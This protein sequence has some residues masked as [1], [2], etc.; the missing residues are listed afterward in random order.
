MKTFVLKSA[1]LLAII[2]ALAIALSAVSDIVKDRIQYRNEAI[3]SISQSHAA[4]QM[5][6]GPTLIVPYEEHYVEV[7][8]K[9]ENGKSRVV[10]TKRSKAGKL[11]LLPEKLK[12]DGT[13]EVAPRY[14]GLF[15]VNTYTADLN[16]SG[17][18]LV[19][20]E[21][22]VQGSHADSQILFQSLASA[23]MHIADA[24]GIQFA[25]VTID[26][27]QIEPQPG[28]TLPTYATGLHVQAAAKPLAGRTVAF[29][30]RLKIVGTD[31]I[32]MLPLGRHN[33][34]AL[35]SP[36]PH[37]SFGGGTLPNQR[38]VTPAG[39]SAT[40]EVTSLASQ[41]R[42]VWLDALSGPQK[43]DLATHEGFGVRLID[44]VDVYTLTDRATKYGVLFIVFVLG[45]Y[46]AY[47]LLKRLQL[48]PVQYTLCGLA[49]VV[50]F[51]LLLGLA[52]Q[53]GFAAAYAAASTACVA[54]LGFYG[55]YMFGH[56]KRSIP[57]TGGLSTM[58][59]ALYLLLHSEQNAVL[60]GSLVLFTVIAAI[61]IGTRNVDWFAVFEASAPT[62]K[63]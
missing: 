7:E 14:R 26:G 30:M 45:A 52:E 47:E 27:A 60:I 13:L 19:P 58:F 22:E 29:A 21:A 63:A 5:I 15:K 46:S 3:A 44:P 37:P 1:I 53:I 10:R 61:M 17:E 8:T 6:A 23:A 12:F 42:Q 41:A 50:F 56:W 28:T 39:F 31:G 55:A 38:E 4:A 25:Q 2:V 40:W 35:N 43:P 51:L 33:I 18:W 36:W 11:L 24:R 20:R 34:A 59:G 49:L 9:E 48:H 16:I 32:T 57:L 54:L 62:S